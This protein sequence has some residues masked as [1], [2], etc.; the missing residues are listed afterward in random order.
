[1]WSILTAAITLEEDIQTQDKN[2]KNGERNEDSL[3]ARTRKNVINTSSITAFYYNGKCHCMW[4]VCNCRVQ[5]SVSVVNQLY[6]KIDL[7]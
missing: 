5:I 7:V 1:M 6:S 4:P 2:G 3:E